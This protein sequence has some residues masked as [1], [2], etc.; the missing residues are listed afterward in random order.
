MA[1]PAREE[2]PSGRQ[3]TVTPVD[4]SNYTQP[5]EMAAGSDEFYRKGAD[6]LAADLDFGTVETEDGEDLDVPAFL[7]RGKN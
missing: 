2:A 5:N 3:R 1:D 6:N 7:R 4:T